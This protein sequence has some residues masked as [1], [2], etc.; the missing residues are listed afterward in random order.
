MENNDIT[1]ASFREKPKTKIEVGMNKIPPPIPTI[2]E[3]VPIKIP[4]INA[5]TKN[6]SPNGKVFRKKV[7]D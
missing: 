4:K 6:S 2:D 5:N 1:T 7:K 3:I